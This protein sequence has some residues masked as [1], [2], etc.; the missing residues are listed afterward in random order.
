MKLCESLTDHDIGVGEN[1]HNQCRNYNEETFKI[2]MKHKG[3][4]QNIKNLGGGG[5]HPEG[6]KCNRSTRSPAVDAIKV[7]SLKKG[8][9]TCH[10]A[11]GRKKLKSRP[12]RTQNPVK[13]TGKEGKKIIEK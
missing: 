10:V 12:A 8:K 3:D 13:G 1:R 7:P 6:Q 4:L 9:T 5:L 2:L 11:M